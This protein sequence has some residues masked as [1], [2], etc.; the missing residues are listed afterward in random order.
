MSANCTILQRNVLGSIECR[1]AQEAF[2][3]ACARPEDDTKHFCAEAFAREVQELMIYL[4]AFLPITIGPLT[5]AK[6][7]LVE[8]AECALD[9]LTRFILRRHAYYRYP[10]ARE[11]WL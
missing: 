11:V 3:W 10:E 7:D 5:T 8:S 4:G 9:D 2:L 6:P 1:R